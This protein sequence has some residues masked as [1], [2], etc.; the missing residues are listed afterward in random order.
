MKKERGTS[1][2]MPLRL[3]V[4]IS[5]PML[6]LDGRPWVLWTNTRGMMRCSLQGKPQ[7]VQVMYHHRRRPHEQP[8]P[9]QISLREWVARS[10]G[11]VPVGSLPLPSILIITRAAT[12]TCSKTV[13][14]PPNKAILL[15]Q[16]LHNVCSYLHCSMHDTKT[17]T[18]SW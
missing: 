17:T 8:S 6:S 11:Y 15:L 13:G 9:A 4:R 14:P 10:K 18:Y 7:W 12:D 1:T 3:G 2:N 5:E 16:T